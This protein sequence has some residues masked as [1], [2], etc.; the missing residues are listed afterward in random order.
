[1]PYIL[2]PT[3]TYSSH[4]KYD[5]LGRVAETT[6]FHH[7]DIPGTL[8]WQPIAYDA[9]GR[10]TEERLGNGVVNRHAY[11]ESRGTLVKCLSLK[12]GTPIQN[13]AYEWNP[14]GNLKQRRDV[15]GGLTEDFDYDSLNRLKFSQ[16]AG[17]ARLDYDYT[18]SGNIRSKANVGTYQYTGVKAN[19]SPHAVT[20]IVGTDGVNR[21]FEYDTNGA[22]TI[23]R[24]NGQTYREVVW[25][26]HQNI[27]S[28][29]LNSGPRVIKVKPTPTSP[30]EE[31]F[32][33][34]NTYTTF[35]YD[36]SFSRTQKVV[37]RDGLTREITTY[38]GS[39]E[40]ID[41]QIR[42]SGSNSWVTQKTEHRH[43]IGGIALKT[44]TELSGGGSSDTTVYFLRDHIGSLT[45]IV[46]EAGIVTERYSSDAW[47]SRRDATT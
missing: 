11:D 14:I 2:R 39:Y 17:R 3:L 4:V 42:P 13:M 27:K 8:Y 41:H 6:V 9:S 16:V 28:L 26:P 46:N 23:E 44:T 37:E 31:I 18:V 34:G 12:D 40:R 47:G 24:R 21:D 7:G 30:E 35:D 43:T 32:G 33:A 38:L 29:T 25:A 19:N 1:M 15:R 22:F 10:L 20:R 36:A 5:S 45:A